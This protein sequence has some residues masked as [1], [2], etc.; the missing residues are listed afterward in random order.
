[1]TNTMLLATMIMA[2]NTT[3]LKTNVTEQFNKPGDYY[4]LTNAFL[5]NIV[6]DGSGWKQVPK[7]PKEKWTVTEVIRIN[8]LQFEWNGLRTVEDTEVISRTTN[9]LKLIENWQPVKP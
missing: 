3:E 7:N 6:W 2:T 8:R 4:I 5:D 9:H 1:M